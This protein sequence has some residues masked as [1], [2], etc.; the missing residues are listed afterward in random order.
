MDALSITRKEWRKLSIIEQGYLCKNYEVILLDYWI[1]PVKKTLAQITPHI[2]I[3]NTQ[4]AIDMVS[5][6]IKRFSK[7]MEGFKLY[8][9]PKKDYSVL[10]G[11][12][13]KSFRL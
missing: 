3:K 9:G 7:E 1:N 2:T 11:K 10:M 4:K 8:D 6:G 13:P 12:K 5:N